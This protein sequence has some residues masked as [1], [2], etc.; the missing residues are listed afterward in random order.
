MTGDRL[1]FVKWAES[2]LPGMAK[3]LHRERLRVIGKLCPHCGG[4]H[5]RVRS[6]MRCHV[7]HLRWD[8]RTR[9]IRIVYGKPQ[10]F[11]T[12]E[13]MEKLRVAM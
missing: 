1:A 8:K 2:T 4:G 5:F 6:Q 13:A 12:G 3:R 10:F 11:I 7:R 9:R